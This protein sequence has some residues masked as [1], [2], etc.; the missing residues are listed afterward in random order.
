MARSFESF[1]WETRL[2][3]LMTRQTLN[4]AQSSRFHTALNRM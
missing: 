3:N 1:A 2:C 4:K